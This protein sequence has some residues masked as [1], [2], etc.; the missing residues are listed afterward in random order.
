MDDKDSK[1]FSEVISK[2]MILRL[3]KWDFRS[4]SGEE[5]MYQHDHN[6]AI[7]TSKKKKK[8]NQVDHQ[9]ASVER[10]TRS[11]LHNHQKGASASGWPLKNYCRSASFSKRGEHL[12]PFQ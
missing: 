4:S 9:Q 11:A 2:P 5:V 8:E 6:N 10:M 7:G 12:I 1:E 3:E